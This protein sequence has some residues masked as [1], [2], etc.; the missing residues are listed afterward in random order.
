MSTKRTVAALG[1]TSLLAFLCVAPAI[2]EDIPKMEKQEIQGTGPNVD[3]GASKGKDPSIVEQEK[4]N[5]EGTGPDV[6]P[7]ASKGKDPSI[8]DQE[9]KDLQ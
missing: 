3:P 4:T 2:A 9:K 8:V 5:I 6:D 1:A 7:G